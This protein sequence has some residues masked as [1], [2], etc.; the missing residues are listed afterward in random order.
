MPANRTDEASQPDKDRT[1][2]TSPADAAEALARA[3]QHARSAASEAVAAVHALLDAAALATSGLPS[4]ANG[5]LAPLAR[6]LESLSEGL[7]PAADVA[8]APLLTALAEALDAEIARWEAR[9][10]DDAE[11]RAVLRAFLGVREL[12]WELGLRR[13]DA[14]PG[15]PGTEQRAPASGAASRSPRSVRRRARVQRVPVQG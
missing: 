5:V 11:A 13:R 6:L 2:R 10:R 4:E 14:S 3:R 12:L 15:E 7:A 8:S 1:F 9:A